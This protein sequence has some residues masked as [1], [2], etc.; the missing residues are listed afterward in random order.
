MARPEQVPHGWALGR[1]FRLTKDYAHRPEFRKG[2]LVKCVMVS[3]FG[4]CGLTKD[5]KAENGYNLRVP[6]IELAPVEAPPKSVCP[7]CFYELADHD[8]KKCPKSAL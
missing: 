8:G 5:L 7:D 3:R 4:D 1:L 2:D 6:P